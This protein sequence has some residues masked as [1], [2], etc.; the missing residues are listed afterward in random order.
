MRDLTSLQSLASL[1]LTLL[2]PFVALA[3]DG[4]FRRR[5]Q[6]SSAPATLAQPMQLT[7]PTTKK[8]E[9]A[10]DYHGTKI[11]DPYRW[12]EDLDSDETRQ[13]VEAQNKVTFAWLAHVPGRE[14][15]RRRLTEL[16]N[17]ERY[18]LPHKKGG[19]YFYTRNDGLQNQN[20]VYVV[21][22]L[23]GQP[24]LLLDPNTLSADG[25]I[26]LTNWVASE[27][28]KLL[29]YGLAGAGSDWQELHVLDVASG[30][31]RS[32]HL[33]WIKFS[34]VSWTPDGKGFFYS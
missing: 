9:H 14:A 25:T 26:A 34:R 27:D 13:W 23:D 29:A 20:A 3:A 4:P 6:Q 16:W 11:A 19:R 7:Y 1:V 24:R 5:Q 32:D 10:D 2:L 17:Y 28:G 31:K 18:G 21:D 33:K 22:R 30:Q 12:L 8:V 15:I